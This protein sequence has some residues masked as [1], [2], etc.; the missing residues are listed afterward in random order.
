MSI[1]GSQ[2]L[3][4]EREQEKRRNINDADSEDTSDNEAYI[5]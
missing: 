5:A 1:K 2:S 3:K 4:R